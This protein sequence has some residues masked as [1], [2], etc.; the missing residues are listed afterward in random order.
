MK[1]RDRTAT[2]A[3]R[4]TLGA[5]DNAEAVAATAVP[6]TGSEGVAGA[7]TGIGAPEVTRR[8]LPESDIAAIVTAE[9]AERSDAAE[10][11][12]RAGRPERAEELRA[13]TA[14]LTALLAE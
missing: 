14:V 6:G 11:Y 7:V 5:I 8:T 9:I 10:T 3:L 12:D 2:A 13:E 4:T 1:A